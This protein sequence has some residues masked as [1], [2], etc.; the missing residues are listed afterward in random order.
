MKLFTQLAL[1]SAIASCGSA[2]AMQTM[3]DS[4]LSDTTGQDGITILIGPPKLATAVTTTGDTL[5]RTNGIVI[6]AAVLHDKDG[7]AGNLGGGA[8]IIGDAKQANTANT[9][10]TAMGIYGSTP[11]KVVI[12][13]SNGQAASGTGG[14]KPILNIAVSLPADLLIRTGDISVDGS[15]RAGIA[16]GASGATAANAATG[17]TTGN[18]VKILNSMDIALG[19]STLN[20]QLGNTQQ[21]GITPGQTTMI[22]LGGS[23]AGG[24]SIAN[25]SI[26]DANTYNPTA[27]QFGG[28]DLGVSMLTVKDTGGTSLTLSAAVDVVADA[29]Q[30]FGGPATGVGGL[31]VTSGGPAS[32][33][34]MQNVTLGST[35]STLGDLQLINVQAAGTHIAIMGH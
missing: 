28:G 22:K 15:A 25:L 35:T 8:I 9:A 10:G 4:A 12:D 18:A 31:I 23:I 7:F 3:D 32:D 1:V 13:A 27:G 5:T 34:M 24:L 20:I 11:I 33:I 6:G 16:T 19:G 17:G 29:S 2:Y 26:H 21:A 30:A 14:T